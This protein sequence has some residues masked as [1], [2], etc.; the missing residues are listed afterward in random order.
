MTGAK[1]FLGETEVSGVTATATS[2]S[3]NFPALPSGKYILRVYVSNVGD[4]ILGD[5]TNVWNGEITNNFWVGNPTPSSGSSGG[6]LITVAVNGLDPLKR[7]RVVFGTN[8]ECAYISHTASQVVCRTPK[9]NGADTLSVIQD[10][11]R[12]VP[13]QVKLAGG[14]YTGSAAGAPTITSAT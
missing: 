8:G 7:P 4:A 11:S 13:S 12:P 2:V 10:I 6:N 5:L 14:T 3:F 1:V 9:I